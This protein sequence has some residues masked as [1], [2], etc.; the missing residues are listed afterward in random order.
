MK[1]RLTTQKSPKQSL[2]R[3]FTTFQMA[4]VYS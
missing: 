2:K 1:Y 3:K 4:K